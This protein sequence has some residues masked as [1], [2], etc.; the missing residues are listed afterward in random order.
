MKKIETIC[1]ESTMQ[2]IE[3]SLNDLIKESL[4]EIQN[5]LIELG[6]NMPV[7]EPRSPN[8]EINSPQF[9][10]NPPVP[11]FDYQKILG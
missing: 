6:C 2:M 1:E 4:D 10:I 9:D 8:P 7:S 11:K 5:T 3:S